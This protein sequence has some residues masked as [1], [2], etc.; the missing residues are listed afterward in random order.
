[1]ATVPTLDNLRLRD[2]GTGG[3]KKMATL[4]EPPSPRSV[5][6]VKCE[7]WGLDPD[8]YQGP[9]TLNEWNSSAG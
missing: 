1:M 3:K 4:A 7:A 2:G 9:K 8:S 5:L 6:Q